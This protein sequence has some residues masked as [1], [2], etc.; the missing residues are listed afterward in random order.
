MKS[1]RRWF[2]TFALAVIAI[3]AASQ[4]GAAPFVETAQLYQP[5]GGAGDYFA[6][7]VAL[8]GDVAVASADNFNVA[9]TK[10]GI[11]YVFVRAAG[12]W[13]QAATLLP[14]D[15]AI[16]D[17]FGNA[18]AISGD[19]I[20]VGAPNASIGGGQI[21]KI[22]VFV[23]PAGGWAGTLSE[24]A[25]LEA[26]APGGGNAAVG[27]SVAIAP[28]YIAG[29][30]MAA[31]SN[32]PGGAVFVFSEPSSGWSGTLQPSGKLVASD[33]VSGD[34]LG[35]TVAASGG[36]VVAGAIGAENEQ[37]KRAG[38]AYLFVEPAGGWN[39]V[40]SE[41][42]QLVPSDA[43]NGAL[44]GTAV[45]ID[46]ST[47]V[48][49]DDFFYA[50][51]PGNREHGYV[52]EQPSGGWSGTLTQNATLVA[53][54]GTNT[55]AFGVSAS[56]SGDTVV[57]GS[58]RGSKVQGAAYLFVRPAGGWAGTL[59][60]SDELATG[61]DFSWLGTSVS[62]SGNT[63]ITGAPREAVG[64]N[65]DQGVAH[66]WEPFVSHFTKSRFLIK[67]PVR[68]APGV[69][70]EFPVRVEARA[71][72]PA[73]PTGD[74]VIGDAGGH[75]CRAVLNGAGEGSCALTFS[76]TGTY[77]VRAHY[78]GNAQFDDSTSPTLPVLVGRG[79]GS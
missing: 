28:G 35:Q 41:A 16:G 26:S 66:V 31:G 4:V 23:R 61:A 5:G 60:E 38:K 17:L 1:A 59:N 9:F 27:L 54:D 10:R 36:V 65:V 48:V 25:V 13:T 55:D 42:A 32:A 57:V 39:G 46:G 71:Q 76:G 45:A 14:S 69:P 53:S 7:R 6:S 37:Y 74:V 21:G 40:Q 47:V 73:E 44:F 75:E 77:R 43:I 15:S 79:G 19:T 70:V 49:T 62:I 63:I 78:L 12:T 29:G 51:V 24:S 8:D 20:A 67:G 33:G 72:A 18:V 3:F 22:Y 52:F 56:I 50:S 30:A 34:Q 58:L 68:V 2:G 11:A 64:G